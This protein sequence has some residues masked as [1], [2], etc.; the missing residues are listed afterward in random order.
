MTEWRNVSI[1]LYKKQGLDFLLETYLDVENKA[2]LWA[3][4]F[5]DPNGP[6][7]DDKG[8]KYRVIKNG[9]VTTEADAKR[10]AEET[11]Y[12]YRKVMFKK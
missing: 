2:W 9:S 6:V 5:K 10:L 7:K 4:F 8:I 11:L 12:D 3:A 1:R